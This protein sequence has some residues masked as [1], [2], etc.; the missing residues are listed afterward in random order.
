MTSACCRSELHN[1]DDIDV[2]N[3]WLEN[4]DDDDDGNDDE[5]VAIYNCNID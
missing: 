3:R 2:I 1:T 5:V 4:D